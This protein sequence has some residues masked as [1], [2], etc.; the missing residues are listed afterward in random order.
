MSRSADDASMFT[1]EVL[2]KSNYTPQ[3]SSS[4]LSRRVYAFEAVNSK[5][6]GESSTEIDRR[7]W[8]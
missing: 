8:T 7:P 6:I 5:Q 3:C 4:K 1:V 2:K